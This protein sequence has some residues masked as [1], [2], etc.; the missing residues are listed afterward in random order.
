MLPAIRTN[1]A[2]TAHAAFAGFF[3]LPGLGQKMLDK[4]FPN[5][6]LVVTVRAHVEDSEAVGR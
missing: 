2:C 4:A 1:A 3:F 6:L 5:A